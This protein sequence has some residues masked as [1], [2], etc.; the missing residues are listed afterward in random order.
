MNQKR[1]RVC[2]AESLSTRPLNFALNTLNGHSRLSAVPAQAGANGNPVPDQVEDKHFQ[3][4]MDSRFRGNDRKDA[5]F[6]ALSTN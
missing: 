2:F 3:L 6:K 5:F 4:V 1:W